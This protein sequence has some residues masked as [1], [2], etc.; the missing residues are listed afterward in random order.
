[1]T[2][3]N[4]DITDALKARVESALADRKALSLVAGNS[5]PF[6]G[7]EIQAEDFDLSGHR[8]IV[9]YEPSELVVTVRGGTRLSEL[10][11][12]LAANGQ[13][14]PFEPPH[15]GD[16]ATVGGTIACGLSGPRRPYAGAARDYVLGTHVINGRGEMLGF[17][18]QVMKNVAGYDVSRLMTGAMGTLGILLDISMKVLP[19]PAATSTQ[20][21]DLDLAAA[22]NRMNEWAGKPIPLSAACHDGRQLYVRISGTAGGVR[23]AVS[24]LGGEVLDDGNFW[25]ELREHELP[26]FAAEGVL[27]RIS[28]PANTPPLALP[29]D[30][31]ADWGGALRWLRSDADADS[32]R[33][34]VAAVG[35]HATLFKGGDRRGQVFHPLEPEVLKLHQRLKMAFD[36]QGIFNPGKMYDGV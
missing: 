8:G 33:S 26:F 36:P 7:R 22:I 20:V 10:E 11:K 34:V 4:N 14:L 6:L 32:I 17:G 21:F 12:T 5:K 9:S 1:M 19:A 18:G 3:D 25:Q 23:T 13:M 2:S 24:R 16:T 28:V 35:G 31:I 29:G 15:Y 27:W 30:T